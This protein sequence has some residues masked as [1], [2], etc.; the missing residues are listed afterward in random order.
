MGTEHYSGPY[1]GPHPSVGGLWL[2]KHAYPSRHER[3]GAGLQRVQF[4][5]SEMNQGETL[6]LMHTK[7]M[8]CQIFLNGAPQKTDDKMYCKLSNAE[9]II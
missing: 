7:Y 9:N 5:L 4:S 3:Q 1:L 6:E 8:L 2:D